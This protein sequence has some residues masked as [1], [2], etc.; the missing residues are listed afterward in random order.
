MQVAINTDHFEELEFLDNT[1]GDVDYFV[2]KTNVVFVAYHDGDPLQLEF[3]REGFK[4][5]TADGKSTHSLVSRELG[6]VDKQSKDFVKVVDLPITPP[7]LLPNQIT[8]FGCRADGL[9]LVGEP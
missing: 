5:E 8:R 7:G 1:V 9:I 6:F 4:E 2:Y 3:Y